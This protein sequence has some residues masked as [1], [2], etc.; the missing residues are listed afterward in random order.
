M[1]ATGTPL[2]A[3]RPIDPFA[4]GQG[5][6]Y[7]DDV[8][9]VLRRT[10]LPRRSPGFTAQTRSFAVGREDA[11]LLLVHTLRLG[12]VDDDVAGLLLDGELFAPGWVVGEDTFERLLT[13][14][15]LS[16]DDDPLTCWEAF[17]RTSLRRLDSLLGTPAGPHAPSGGAGGTDEGGPRTLTGYAP[18]YERAEHLVRAVGSR[19]LLDLGTCFGFFPL[20]MAAVREVEHVTA[21]D[22]VPGTCEL[23]ARMSLRLRRPI[24]VLACDAA[25]VPLPAMA[26]DTVTLLHLLEHV[27]AAH[28]ARI[29]DEAMRLARRRVVVAVPL[30]DEPCAAFGHVRT[31]SVAGLAAW[32]AA[33]ARGGGWQAHVAEHHGGWLVLDRAPA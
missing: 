3:P 12:E 15:V 21:V 25:S 13:G 2:P 32:G 22:I 1:A 14:I 26:V 17:Y 28:G 31:L 6:R 10:R 16:C 9:V 24:P 33:I 5:G 23:L 27:D 20:R 4:A 11:R 30:E 8:V 18:V 29:V 19:S 7:E